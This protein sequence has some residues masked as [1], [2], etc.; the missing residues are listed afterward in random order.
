[1]T[2]LEL[3]HQ[4]EDVLKTSG[5]SKGT[6]KSTKCVFNHLQHYL[7]K[8]QNFELTHELASQFLLEK[9]GTLD[10]DALT[11]SQKGS[12]R[13]VE[14]LTTWLESKELRKTKKRRRKIPFEGKL[15]QSF[16]DFLLRESHTKH[17]ATLK[18]HRTRLSHLYL[19]LYERNMVCMDITTEI[20]IGFLAHLEYKNHCR[21][22]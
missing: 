21:K 13:C 5:Y 17:P 20:M 7:E 4:V 16:E 9:N 12:V 3:R 6:L 2:F 19:Y 15:G 18:H 1:M 11:K 8:G 10:W 14:Y 22:R